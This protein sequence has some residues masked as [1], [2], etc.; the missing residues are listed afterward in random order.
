MAPHMHIFA[1]TCLWPHLPSHLDLSQPCCH[2]SQSQAPCASVWTC[3]LGPVPVSALELF[4]T[5]TGPCPS[6]SPCVLCSDPAHLLW[7]ASLAPPHPPGSSWLIPDMANQYLSVLDGV[8][9]ILGKLLHLPRSNLS[10]AGTETKGKWLG[11][12]GNGMAGE[13]Y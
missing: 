10:R 9:S 7:G 5:A 4:E 13:C 1:W 2:L 11:A 8:V 3:C 12:A 6:S